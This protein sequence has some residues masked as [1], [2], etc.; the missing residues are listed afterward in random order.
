[1]HRKW[2]NAIWEIRYSYFSLLYLGNGNFEWFSVT[3]LIG[4]KGNRSCRIVWIVNTES[5]RA[6]RNVFF[7]I[8]LILFAHLEEKLVETSVP[9]GQI[10]MHFS[11]PQG[12]STADNLGFRSVLPAVLKIILNLLNYVNYDHHK[13]KIPTSVT[14]STYAESVDKI[15]LQIH[16]SRSAFFCFKELYYF[17]RLQMLKV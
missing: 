1:M 12:S 10:A 15:R 2:T 13:T 8:L 16:K 14:G 7:P 9:P 5:M 17:S 3:V 11:F 6:S 4:A